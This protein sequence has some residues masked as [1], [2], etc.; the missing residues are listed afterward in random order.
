MA[1]INVLHHRDF[2]GQCEVRG[3]PSQRRTSAKWCAIIWSVWSFVIA[4][5]EECVMSR[6]G[7]AAAAAIIT[8]FI[9]C[10]V[11]GSWQH[12]RLGVTNVYAA[13]RHSWCF[14][15]K[16]EAEFVKSNCQETYLACPLPGFFVCCSCSLP[17]CLL[18]DWF[19]RAVISWKDIKCMLCLTDGVS[20]QEASSEIRNSGDE[21]R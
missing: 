7:C 11:D 17:G 18:I 1:V 12:H 20:K 9:N 14:H 8:V 6:E 10:I 16:R 4:C 19:H 21:D 13:G 2:D 5:G 3:E 15:E